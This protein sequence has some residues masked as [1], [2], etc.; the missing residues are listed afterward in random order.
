M[1]LRWGDPILAL[2]GPRPLTHYLEVNA[3][4][5]LHLHRATRNTHRSYVKVL[6]TQ[7]CGPAIAPLLT[8]NIHLY[9]TSLAMQSQIALDGPLPGRNLLNFG[10]VELDLLKLFAVQN[11]W[12]QHCGLNLRAI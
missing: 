7:Q 12:P 1:Q 8:L 5:V 6:L 10:R 9:G 11:F 3:N 2:A 4:F